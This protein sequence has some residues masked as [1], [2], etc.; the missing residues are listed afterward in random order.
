M[1]TVLYRQCF[2]LPDGRQWWKLD[3][4]TL[5]NC[6]EP[7]IRYPAPFDTCMVASEAESVELP[8][9]C[10]IGWEN[11]STVY[12]L[13][14]PLCVVQ[15]LQNRGGKCTDMVTLR[16]WLVEHLGVAY[17]VIWTRSC[18]MIRRPRLWFPW[19]ITRVAVPPI[20]GPCG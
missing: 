9:G 6:L 7:T 8:A 17:R 14:V 5:T 4:C 3:A 11:P 1:N 12:V 10:E 16:S 2:I 15:T 18:N 13:R 19:A 20:P